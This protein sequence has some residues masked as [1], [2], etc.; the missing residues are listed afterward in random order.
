MI[1]HGVDFFLIHR[2]GNEGQRAA[3]GEAI[4]QRSIDNDV[5]SS[6]SVQTGRVREIVLEGWS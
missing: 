2:R 4:K 1:N 5:S 3:G 6:L